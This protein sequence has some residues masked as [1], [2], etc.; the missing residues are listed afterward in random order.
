MSGPDRR[1]FLAATGGLGVTALAPAMAA[2]SPAILAPD[3]PRERLSLDRDWRF[4]ARDVPFPV[5]I[6]HEESY[7]N[8]K[9]GNATGA[10]ATDYDD[11]DWD[12]VDLPHDFAL[13]QP[14]DPAA[15]M[16]QGY[17]RRGIGWYRRTFLLPDSDRDRHLELQF[18]GIA[19]FATVWINGNLVHRHF[20][21]YTGF[22]ID[23]TP[24]AQFGDDPNT[25][26]VRVDANAMEGWWYE[27]A[28][29]YRHVWLVRRDR[30][31]IV[32]DGVHA[33]PRRGADGSWSVPVE[34]I[35][36]DA[37]VSNAG[38]AARDVAV[39]A[40]L[41]DPGGRTV[42]A[43]TTTTALASLVH[44][45]AR[46]TLAVAGAPALW[47]VETPTLHIVRVRLRVGGVVVDSIDLWIGFRTLRFDADRG[48]FLNDRPLKI[49]GVC[50]HQDHAGVGVA[51]PDALWDFRLRRIKAMGGNAI[52][53]SHNAPAA[54]LLDA[55]D[56]LGVLVMD[57]NRNFN[58]SEDDLP[59]L[60]WLV[61]RDRNHPSVI[62]WSI[63]NEESIQGTPMGARI[64]RRMVAAVRAL[65]D[66]RPVTAAMNGG[67]FATDTI[68][69]VI[70]VVG[71]NYEMA[72]YDRYH[73]ARPTKPLFSSEDTSAYMTRGEY[74]TDPARH[75][76]AADDEQHAA[77]GA[78][79]RD[80]WRM[81]DERPFLAGGFVW[82]GFD[83]RGEPTPYEWPT[84]GASFGAM[85]L[86]GFPKTAFFIRRALWTQGRPVLHL[87]PHWTWP[88]REGQ[89]IKVMAITNADRVVLRL[90][91]RIVADLAVDR[92]RM[93]GCD[94]PYAP[95]RLEAMAY[96]GGTRVAH[97]AVET[98]GPPARLRLT[99]DRPVMAADG[100]DA[101]P[102]TVEAIDAKG[103]AVPTAMNDVAFAVEGGRILGLG[104]GDPNSHEPDR[105]GTAGAHRRLFNGLA[106]VIVQADDARGLI[107]TAT[108]PGL[109]AAIASIAVRPAAPRPSV[110]AID[111]VQTLTEWRQSPASA[112]PPDPLQVLTDD[113]MN[114]WSWTKPGSAQNPVPGLR[115]SCFR[116]VFTPR[117]AVARSGGRIVFGRLEGPVEIRLDGNL[118][119]VKT[120]P[121]P[122][123]VVVTLPGGAIEHRLA[124][125]FDAP[126][127]PFGIA[128]VV[129]VTGPPPIRSSR[130]ANGSG[131]G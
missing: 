39:E 107:L 46:L 81:I 20:T 9:A 1:Q 122:A 126:A 53:C 56:R 119:S 86:C 89:A 44:A 78:T 60:E 3:S 101:Q 30:V 12:R 63:C 69:D 87:A 23:L 99:P 10:A 38:G 124:L 110:A 103:R 68:A 17:R 40:V 29:L 48:F 79:H 21:G 70:D 115:Y 42:V 26:A 84:V 108:S 50:V 33:D 73:A 83:Y 24:Y 8:A 71:F 85:D 65:D 57:E 117:A 116:I 109:G 112:T 91:G 51:V 82:T 58:A 16:A 123:R 104:N 13:D 19:T 125:S 35:V 90:D 36:Y 75:V 76:L 49:Q 18:D 95:G 120:D 2:A 31:H 93:A 100:H 98:T 66:G 15:N 52:R 62:L 7:A 5:P 4:V 54:E 67:M 106:Q 96:R 128:G 64:A 59:Q 118:V 6:G 121:G 14:F 34:A 41:I 105:P 113:D 92:Y 28:G 131:I 32:T 72:S 129:K 130:R 11:S 77:W 111:S 88:G 25:L 127:V 43:G 114:S 45:T 22:T 94:I 97:A 37:G 27:G 55:A 80:A 74:R 47:S 102:V 61:R